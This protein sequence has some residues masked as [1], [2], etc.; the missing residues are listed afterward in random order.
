MRRRNKNK[1]ICYIK[2]NAIL[3]LAKSLGCF[4]ENI[5]MEIKHQF[6]MYNLEAIIKSKDFCLILQNKKRNAK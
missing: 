3:T 6:K 5:P 2:H 1:F 4:V